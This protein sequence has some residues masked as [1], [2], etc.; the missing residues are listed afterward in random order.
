MH[1]YFIFKDLVTIYLFLLAL[2][3]IVFYTPN[4][5][6]LK[7]WPNV[8]LLIVNITYICAIC[9]KDIL[10]FNLFKIYNKTI[11]ISGLFIMIILRKYIIKNIKI[12]RAHV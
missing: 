4:L 6:G 2:S 9:W 3:I 12:G 5:L 1:P 11:I 8:I 7:I 10:K